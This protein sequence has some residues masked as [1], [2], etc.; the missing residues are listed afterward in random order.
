MVYGYRFNSKSLFLKFMS[1]N[2]E[3]DIYIKRVGKRRGSARN[4]KP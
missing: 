1:A 3:V 4:H 2:F